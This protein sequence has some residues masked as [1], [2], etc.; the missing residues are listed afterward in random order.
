MQGLPIARQRYPKIFNE[1]FPVRWNMPA[2]YT[3]P[4]LLVLAAIS[5]MIFKQEMMKESTSSLLKKDT[6]FAAWWTINKVMKDIGA[7]VYIVEP[8]L[9]SDLRITNPKGLRF[10]DLKAPLPSFVV[11]LP[12]GAFWTINDGDVLHLAI[13]LVDGDI[14]AIGAHVR[15]GATF[16]FLAPITDDDIEKTLM[17]RNICYQEYK[18]AEALGIKCRN[19]CTAQEDNETVQQITLFVINLLAYMTA[20]NPD[21]EEAGLVKSARKRGQ[22]TP[23]L[24]DRAYASPWVI[25]KRYK[26]RIKAGSS[27]H[28]VRAHWRCG[29][30][31]RHAHGKDK[32]LRRLIYI[33][34]VFVNKES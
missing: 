14:L 19:N 33:Q 13:T 5:Q 25:G 6:C 7:R 10:S 31:R 28:T 3:N 9:I 12:S 20:F 32:A 34:P 8:D 30:W 4:E 2:N 24:K 29:H 16:T 11:S 17:E 26:Q 21:V 15:S 23:A 27:G 22:E 18:W 1:W